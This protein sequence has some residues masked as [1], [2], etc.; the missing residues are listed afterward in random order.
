MEIWQIFI[1][2]WVVVNV[3]PFLYWVK[4]KSDDGAVMTATFLDRPM[5]WVVKMIIVVL[6]ALFFIPAILFFGTFE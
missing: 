4:V 3:V 5:P 6:F 2:L 1:V